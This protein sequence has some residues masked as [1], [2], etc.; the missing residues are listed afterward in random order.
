MFLLAGEIV[1]SQRW[2][3]GLS[4][5]M[6]INKP[7]VLGVLGVVVGSNHCAKSFM[8]LTNDFSFIFFVDC[9][10]DWT[11]SLIWFGGWA[12]LWTFIPIQVGDLRSVLGVLVVWRVVAWLRSI[13]R[14]SSLMLY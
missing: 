7:F 6:N 2:H 14:M 8:L 4:F 5:L 10:G 3:E 1:F 13:Q 11:W 9:V 12:S